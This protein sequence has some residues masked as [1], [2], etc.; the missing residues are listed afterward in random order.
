MQSHKDIWFSVEDQHEHIYFR[1]YHKPHPV[2]DFIPWPIRVSG[3][4]FDD[5][6]SLFSAHHDRPP[7][8]ILQE[9]IGIFFTHSPI[10]TLTI[11]AD[12]PAIQTP[13]LQNIDANGF[14]L[15]NVGNLTANGTSTF[16][17]FSKFNGSA[18]FDLDISV[19]DVAQF[20]AQVI[21]YDDMT[22]LG[23]LQVNTING[24]PY[25]PTAWTANIDGNGFAL[26]N[27]SSINT[28]Y[29]SVVGPSFLSGN[30]VVSGTIDA[31][32]FINARGYLVNSVEFAFESGGEIELDNIGTIN[33]APYPPTSGY[34]PT[35]HDVTGSRIPIQTYPNPSDGLM[36]VS[37]QVFLQEDE[38]AFAYINVPGVGNNILVAQAAIT[39]TPPTTANTISSYLFFAVPAGATYSIDTAVAPVRWI[40][41]Y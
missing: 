37:V 39:I 18:S 35:P 9:G 28:N 10:G 5:G 17:G 33:G 40:E 32:S 36:L 31:S 30:V 16:N 1:A 20:F 3:I 14:S 23:N 41:F 4:Y 24:A 7:G 34:N 13:W 22:V 15:S 6:S 25:P 8:P 38:T 12:I 19:R 27:T 21:A 2:L 11:N 29:L 26:Y